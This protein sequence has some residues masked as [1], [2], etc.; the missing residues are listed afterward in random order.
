M[1][2][3]L[4]G[5]AAFLVFLSA[6]RRDKEW[7]RE[8]ATKRNAAL[9]GLHH[10]VEKPVDTP[11]QHSLLRDRAHYEEMYKESIEQPAAFCSIIASQFH[12][13]TPVRPEMTL[14]PP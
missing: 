9:Q 11:Y 4:L 7:K 2:V 3:E 6:L 14:C 13:Q 10:E 5:L 8:G 12:W 1:G